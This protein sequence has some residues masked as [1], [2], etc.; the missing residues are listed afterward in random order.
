MEHRWVWDDDTS[1]AYCANHCGIRWYDGE[2][3]PEHCPG[4]MRPPATGRIVM[5]PVE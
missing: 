4:D 1:D 2:S 3:E 5:L